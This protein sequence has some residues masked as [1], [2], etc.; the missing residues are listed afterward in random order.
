MIKAERSA[1]VLHS[2][3]LS[4]SLQHVQI[5]SKVLKHACKYENRRA[6]VDIQFD[7][8]VLVAVG[9]R[10]YTEWICQSKNLVQF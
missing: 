6:G 7:L 10:W 9:T 2:I 5:R 3:L 1:I 4:V 8:I